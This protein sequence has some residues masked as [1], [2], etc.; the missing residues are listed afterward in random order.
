MLRSYLCGYSDAYIA[1]KGIIVLLAATSNENNKAQKNDAF[2]NNV[3]F[4]KLRIDNAKD[5]N[6]VISMYNLLEYSQNYFMTSGSL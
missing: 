5:L 3:Q 2:K 6:I 1:V 4:Q